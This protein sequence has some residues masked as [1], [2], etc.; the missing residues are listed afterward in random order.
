M[1]ILRCEHICFNSEFTASVFSFSS[2]ESFLGISVE[3]VTVVF[4]LCTSLANSTI[5]LAMALGASF[6]LMS[7]QHCCCCVYGF[8]YDESVILGY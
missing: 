3:T 4:S 2:L 8:K 7:L 1:L 6:D 5:L